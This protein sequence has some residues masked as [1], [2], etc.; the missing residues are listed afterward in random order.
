MILANL[1][2]AYRLVLEDPAYSCV[3]IGGLGV[4]F[5]VVFLLLGFVIQSTSYDRYVPQNEQVYVVKSQF[6]YNGPGGD[7][8]QAAPQ[9]LKTALDAKGMMLKSSGFLPLIRHMSVNNVPHEVR[10]VMVHPEFP[11]VMGLEVA[12]QGD[13]QAALSRPDGLALTEETARRLY[14]DTRVVGR[15]LLAVGQTFQV[16]AVIADP[17]V[18]STFPFEALAGT[19]SRTIT[20]SVRTTTYSDKTAWG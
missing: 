7:W 17:P 18:T 11:Q 15:T 16:L 14:G 19:N 9:I 10:Q 3:V 13:L 4:G 6:N 5:A 8:T 1:R 20:E 12:K 2:L